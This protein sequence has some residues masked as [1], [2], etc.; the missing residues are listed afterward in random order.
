MLRNAN[1]ADPPGLEIS[2]K[3]VSD[4]ELRMIWTTADVDR[5]GMLVFQEFADFLQ[6]CQEA[7]GKHVINTKG[8]IM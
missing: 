8:K 6:K 5:S 7:Y 2:K 3:T 4:K 1:D